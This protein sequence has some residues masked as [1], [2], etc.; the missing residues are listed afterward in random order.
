[1]YPAASTT[2]PAQ[3]SPHRL[4]ERAAAFSSDARFACAWSMGRTRLGFPPCGTSSSGFSPSSRHSRP[5]ALVRTCC[6]LG[7]DPE[8]SLIPRP[9]VAQPL[10]LAAT[11]WERGARQ[12]R[13]HAPRPFPGRP[14]AGLL[15]GASALNARLSPRDWAR[16]LPAL[17]GPA[18]TGPL[19]PALT[20]LGQGAAPRRLPE[21]PASPGS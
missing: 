3:S 21:R 5:F 4:R 7:P 8:A 18:L 13:C 2:I 11:P 20:L 19:A 1:M 15:N 14:H 6:R 9:E 10:S 17:N 12:R 16:G